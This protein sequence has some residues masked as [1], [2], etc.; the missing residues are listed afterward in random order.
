MGVGWLVGWCKWVGGWAWVREL[1]VGGRVLMSSGC[2]RGVIGQ[3]V[4]NKG[5]REEG[6]GAV[7]R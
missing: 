1:K 4:W 7:D 3:Q 5:R 6:G 2:G